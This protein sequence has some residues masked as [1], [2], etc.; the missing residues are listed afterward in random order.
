MQWVNL[1]QIFSFTIVSSFIIRQ[2]QIR[3]DGRCSSGVYMMDSA[4]RHGVEHSEQLACL[5][6]RLVLKV[7][8]DGAIQVLVVCDLGTSGLKF[9]VSFSLRIG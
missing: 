6:H 1:K 3:I 5:H 2:L 8:V 4:L 9:F 7:V